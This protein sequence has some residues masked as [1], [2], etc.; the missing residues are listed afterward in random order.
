MKDI[1]EFI[2]NNQTLIIT[3]VLCATF[4]FNKLVNHFA[5]N[6]KEDLWDKMKPYS[7]AVCSI[8]FDGVE[9]L[10]KSK[11]MTSAMKSLKSLTIIL[12][13]LKDFMTEF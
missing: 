8:V 9:Y 6:P 7:N 1:L 12:N 13:R 4:L 10:A 2:S 5:A 3:V 11:K